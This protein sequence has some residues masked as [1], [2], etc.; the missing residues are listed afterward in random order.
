M[1]IYIIKYLLDNLNGILVHVCRQQTNI[2]SH[3]IDE[4]MYLYQKCEKL[5]DIPWAAEWSQA[6]IPRVVVQT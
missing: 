6:T 5:H 3:N 4:R 2:A 1:L